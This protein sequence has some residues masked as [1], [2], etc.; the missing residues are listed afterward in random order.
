MSIA[1]K[2]AK[3]IG[4]K[5]MTAAEIAAKLKLNVGAVRDALT[6][7]QEQDDFVVS[8]RKGKGRGRPALTYARG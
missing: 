3:V 8:S 4:K 6:P 7:L 2:V 1:E 5:P